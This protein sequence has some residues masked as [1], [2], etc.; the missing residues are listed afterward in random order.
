MKSEPAD[1]YRRAFADDYLWLY[2]HRTEQQARSEV[3]VAAEHLPFETSH[4][5]LDIAC[6]A[7]RHM[8]AFAEIGARV[9]GVD[10]SGVLLDKARRRFDEAGHGARLVRSDMRHLP[11]SYQFDGVTLWFTSFGYFPTETEDLIVLTELSNVL[12]PGGWWWIDIPNPS[13]LEANLVPE[14]EREVD[15]PNG[16]AHVIEKRSIKDGHVVKMIDID[17]SLG[18]RS[19]EERVRLYTPERFGSLIREA[20]LTTLGILGDYDGSPFTPK[21]PRQIWYGVKKE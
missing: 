15:G 12:R 20:E 6:G 21:V 8:L 5:V 18:H 17:D 19:Y 16:T 9:T 11:F 13:H 4:Q 1:W 14:S 7:G 2:S 10:L 3:E